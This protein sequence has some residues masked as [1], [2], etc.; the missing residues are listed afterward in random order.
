MW[1]NFKLLFQHLC[2]ETEE[3]DE[4]PVRIAVS[5]PRFEPGISQI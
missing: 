3:N 5:R 4:K 1:P 2:G